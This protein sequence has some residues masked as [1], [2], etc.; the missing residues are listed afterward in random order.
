MAKT[1]ALISCTVT[2][3][4][5]CV[6]IFAYTNCWFS[7]AAAR[8][9]FFFFFSLW[10]SLCQV[11]KIKKQMHSYMIVKHRSKVSNVSIS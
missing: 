4:L 7:N 11:G 3:Q 10:L 5:I 1:K 8:F 6:F 2:A 9:C